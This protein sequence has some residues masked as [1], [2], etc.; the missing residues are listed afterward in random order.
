MNA[1]NHIANEVF[2]ALSKKPGTP[3]LVDYGLPSPVRFNR[4]TLLVLALRLARDLKREIRED[5]VGIVLPP[6]LAG[7]LANLS[8]F[9]ADKVPVNLNFTLGREAI[10]HSMKEAGIRTV[11]TAKALERKFPDFPWPKDLFDVGERLKGYRREKLSLFRQLFWLRFFPKA[12]AKSNEVPRKGGDKEATLL[13]TSGSSGAPK[14]VVLSHRNLISNCHQISQFGL[15][16][17]DSKILAN[18]P[19]FHSF[20][21]TIATLYPLLDGIMIVSSPSP[22][23]L[24]SSLRAIREE[25][26]DVLMGTPTFLRGYLR[27]AKEEDLKSIKYVVAGA[28]RTSPPFREKWEKEV[29]CK[30]LEGYGLTEASPVLSFNVPGGGSRENSVGRLL[31]GIESKIVHPE[32]KEDLASGETGLLCFRGK[33]VFLGYL[34]QP[35]KTRGVLTEDGWFVTGDLGRIDEDGFLFI[36]GRLSRFSKIAGEM[37]PHGTVEEAVSKALGF[38]EDGDPVCAVIGIEDPSKGERLILLISVEF[39]SEKLR[40]DLVGLGLPNLWIPKEVRKIEE[41]PLL[42]TGK[43]DL[44][45]IKK[46]SERS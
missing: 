9:F 46:L 4:G 14:G 26:V 2:A 8:L 28:E 22:L 13:F 27:K 45:E 33:N 38:A 40:K 23:D 15:F 5:R 7:V 36:E 18:L 1:S 42:P 11:L 20:G 32:T 21:F 39:D 16:A 44:R 31:P 30:Y 10:N 24:S 34:N 25:R 35:E 37:V 41:I 19:L 12:L 6:G 17:K 43:L 29:D 3:V